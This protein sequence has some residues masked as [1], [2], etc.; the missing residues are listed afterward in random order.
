MAV[1][2]DSRICTAFSEQLAPTHVRCLPVQAF[3]ATRPLFYSAV[4]IFVRCS[5]MKRTD[6]PSTV[7]ASMTTRNSSS[8]RIL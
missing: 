4:P 7:S 6:A 3:Y 1:K 5:A 2:P 8:N